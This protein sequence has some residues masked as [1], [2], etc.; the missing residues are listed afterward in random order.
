M[1]FAGLGLLTDLGGLLDAWPL[2]LTI[3]LTVTVLKTAITAVVV[4]FVGFPADVAVRSGIF[5]GQIGEFSFVLG[6]VALRGG[7]IDDTVYNAL[8]GAAIASLLL[9]PLLLSASR[10]WS[11]TCCP[12]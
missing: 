9:N 6:L 5:L 7:V 4:R 3:L 1:F 11:A 8:I 10:P 12:A 2:T